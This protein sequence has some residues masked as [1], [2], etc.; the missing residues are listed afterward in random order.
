VS[1]AIGVG[2]KVTEEEYR[3]IFDTIRFHNRRPGR[4]GVAMLSLSRLMT[5]RS[6]A[7]P[8]IEPPFR[9]RK[10]GRSVRFELTEHTR[11]ADE[12]HK[13]IEKIPPESTIKFFR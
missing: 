12:I 7:T 8:S 5:L 11:Q 2:T 10:T 13:A 6:M 9:Q 3:E 1:G 4:S